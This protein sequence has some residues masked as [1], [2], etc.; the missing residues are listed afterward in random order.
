ML[1]DPDNAS[2]GDAAHKG[3]HTKIVCTAQLLAF[4]KVH[5]GPGKVGMQ[6]NFYSAPPHLAMRRMKGRTLAK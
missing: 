1:H 2:T 6:Y 3:A 4:F 5:D